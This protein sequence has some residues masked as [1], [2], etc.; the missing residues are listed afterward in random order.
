MG[1]MVL[2]EMVNDVGRYAIRRKL[3]GSVFNFF[4]SLFEMG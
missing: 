4:S 1:T 2:Y 3:L